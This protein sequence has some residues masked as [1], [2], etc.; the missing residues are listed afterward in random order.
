M[1]K[2]P[3]TSQR[4]VLSSLAT[5]VLAVSLSGCLSGG[6]GSSSSTSEPQT[7]ADPLQIDTATGEFRGIE[8]NGLRVFRGIP[9]AEPPVGNLR[10]APTVAAVKLEGVQQLSE[11]FSS[12]CPQT[13]VTTGAVT[14]NED[15]LYLNVYAPAE[16]EDLP[17]MVWVHGGAFILGNGGGEYD[18]TRLVEQ[19]VIVVTLNYRLGLLGFM[20]H[21]GLE[22]DGGNFGLMDQ[23]QAL[24]WVKNNIAGFGGNPDNVTL[25]GESA[26]GHSVLS[27]IVSPR[28]Q[29][30]KL[31]NKAIIQSGSYASGQMPKAYAHPAASALLSTPCADFDSVRECVNEL[32]VEQILAIQGGEQ[33]VPTVDPAG[34]LLPVSIAEALSAGEFDSELSIMI[35]SN[36]DEGTLFVALDELGGGMVPLEA[37]GETEYRAR[38]QALLAPFG[39]NGDA[40]ATHYLSEFAGQ[41]S[42]LSLALSAIWTDY[43]FACSSRL[44]AGLFSRQ[45]V[46][47]Y[48]YWFTDENAPWTMVP[49]QI[50]TPVGNIPISFPFGA[51]HAGEIPYI[52]YSADTMRQRYAGSEEDVDRLAGYMVEYWTN[53]AKHGDPNATDGASPSW[54][55]FSTASQALR[56]DLPQPQTEPATAFNDYHRCAYWANPTL[57][58]PLL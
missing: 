4:F 57:N 53:F 22:H 8:L 12:E 48:N 7:P 13:N 30:E 58:P 2:S 32:S 14:G 51:T 11:A 38:V 49:P 43:M 50:P 23:Q 18:P 47:T 41:S 10:L 24:R 36:Q 52:L 46:D 31:F 21:P 17:V 1:Q 15:C 20:A 5:L 19:G 26:G 42:P 56:L 39:I 33:S 55:T 25:F 40:V 34:D 3:I 37:G 35:G 6:G 16:G 27:H 29:E 44:H 9:Y 45:G 54:P 28:A